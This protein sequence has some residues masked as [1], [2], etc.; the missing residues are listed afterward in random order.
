[1]R[2]SIFL[3]IASLVPTIA[4]AQDIVAQNHASGAQSH[5]EHGAAHGR[6]APP[7]VSLSEPGQGAFAALSEVV[8]VLEA[9]PNTDWARVDLGALR[10]HLMDMDRLVTTAIP[11][12]ERLDD[13]LRVVV[14][15]DGATMEAVRRMVPAHAAE[16]A[17]DGRWTVETDVTPDDVVLTVRSESVETVRRIQALGF[18]GLMASQ[19][20]HREH[21][22][23]I[24]LGRSSH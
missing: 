4:V 15:G 9:D 23:G 18:Y 17:K 2:V 16:L 7:T 13:G 1:M 3:L 8:T 11:S 6:A 20:H 12:E 21:H 24:A 19:D 5:T 22:L 14:T 10:D